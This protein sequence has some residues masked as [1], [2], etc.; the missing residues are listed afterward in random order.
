MRFGKRAYETMPTLSEEEDVIV[1]L[2]LLK[3]APM[4]FRKRAP[5]RFGKRFNDYLRMV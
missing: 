2:S 3:K 1:P 5:M 4:R